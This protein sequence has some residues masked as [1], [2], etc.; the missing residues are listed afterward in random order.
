MRIILVAVTLVI[1]ITT[2]LLFAAEPV[3]V[4]D[5]VF[6]IG[7]SEE[8][9]LEYR[10]AAGD[11][12][13]IN[14]VAT[15]GNDISEISVVEWPSSM[16]FQSVGVSAINDKKITVPKTNIFTIHV[17]NTAMLKS[18][19]YQ[20]HIQ[21]IPASAELAGFNTSAEWDTIYDTTYVAQTE[22]VLVKVD[23]IVD[24]ILK[25]ESK[26][27]SQMTG[28]T[29]T[30]L[31]VQ[32]PAR[33]SYWAYWIGV[34]QESAAGLEQMGQSLPEGAALLGLTNPV[35][36]FAVGL[37]PSLF[38]LSQGQSIYY[39]IV[40][41]ARNLQLFMEGQRF[42]ALKAGTVITDYAKMEQ[43]K[44]GVFYVGLSNASSTLTSKIVNV[45]IVVV[46]LIPKYSYHETQ[47]PVVSK[48]VVPRI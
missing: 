6:N 36:L 8:K 7:A 23:T 17:K 24:D 11:T 19:T 21:R 1:Q 47:K 18:K 43:P 15:K 34:G 44:Q 5:L 20:I 30:Y 22:S 48:S 14:A 29:Q 42:Y 35:A 12:I 46:K 40:S 9:S 13:V 33:T 25:T 38:S 32:L 27:G 2:Q 45:N 10:F 39:C 16:K 26:L 41:D 31:T 3:D 37:L 28:N 4:A